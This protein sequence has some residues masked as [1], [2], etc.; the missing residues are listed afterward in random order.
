MAE[1]S[2]DLKS[3]CN[4]ARL[5]PPDSMGEEQELRSGLQQ[6]LVFFRMVDAIDTENVEPL[7]QPFQPGAG[8]ERDDIHVQGLARADALANAPDSDGHHFLV[9]QVLK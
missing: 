4:L 6:I 3:L 9:P 2:I 1:P 5:P 7:V 8:T